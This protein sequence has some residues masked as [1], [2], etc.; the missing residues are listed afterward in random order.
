M[1]L[2]EGEHAGNLI[3]SADFGHGVSLGDLTFYFLGEDQTEPW[4]LIENAVL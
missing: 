2:D 1:L 4:T 3:Q